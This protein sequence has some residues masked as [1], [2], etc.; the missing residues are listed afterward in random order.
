ME[1]RNI[2]DAGNNASDGRRGNVF[3][4]VYRFYVNGFKRMTWGRTMWAIIAIKLFIMFAILKAFLFP[5]FLKQQGD[6]VDE[7]TEYVS[8]EYERRAVE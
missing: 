2:R 8:S 3:G 1:E 5:N 6:S 4:R 7:R